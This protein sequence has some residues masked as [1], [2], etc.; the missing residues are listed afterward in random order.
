MFVL[1]FVPALNLCGIVAG[2]MER[3]TA[4]MGI[5]KTFGA[6]RSTLL[7]QV[8]TENLVLTSIGGIIGLIISWLAIYGF[9]LELLSLFFDSYMMSTA[10][11]VTGEMLFSPLLFVG[12][13]I[14]ILVLN[15]LAAVV[16]AWW[17]LRKPIVESMMERR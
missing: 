3:R 13:F 7:W 14:A 2:R 1:L 10:P 4:E 17:S 5:R 15:L 8:V 9:R 11:I 12:C 16:P 6:R